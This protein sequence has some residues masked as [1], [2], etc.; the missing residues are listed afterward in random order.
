MAEEA[1]GM[2]TNRRRGLESSA[3]RT[4]LMDAVEAVMLDKGSAAVTARSVAARA[5]MNYQLVFYY[6]EGMDDLLL[7]TYRRRTKRVQAIV[8]QALTSD[9]PLHALWRAWSEPADA[10][11]TLE[12]MALSNRHE[13]LRA[14]TIQFGE[15]IRQ[16]VASKL[17]VRGNEA[18]QG[19]FSPLAVG[20]TLSSLGAM[21]GFERT[22]GISGGHAATRELVECCLR[23]LEADG[24][25]VREPLPS[26]LSN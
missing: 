9:R 5:G 15:C 13:I 3:T 22:L 25:V 6:F 20:L 7:T 23:H 11:L 16:R 4:Q 21:I 24:R 14:E 12:Y 10:A 2:G 19:G 26:D 8:E 18:R 17:P 1:N